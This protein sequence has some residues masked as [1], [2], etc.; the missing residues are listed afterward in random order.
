MKNEKKSIKIFGIG[1]SLLMI[2]MA[3]ISIASAACAYGETGYGIEEIFHP[4]NGQPDQIDFS[5]YGTN[6][7]YRDEVLTWLKD[8]HKNDPRYEFIPFEYTITPPRYDPK[9]NDISI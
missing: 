3:F 1:A 4:G 2:L 8:S 9:Q 6:K 5:I 7:A